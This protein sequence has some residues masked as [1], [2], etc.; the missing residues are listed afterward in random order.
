MVSKLH[1]EIKHVKFGDF[2]QLHIPITHTHTEA[3]S[4]LP[5]HF[6][7]N[8]ECMDGLK[9][10]LQ[11]SIVAFEACEGDSFAKRAN[12]AK[13][14]LEVLSRLNVKQEHDVHDAAPPS[15]EAEEVR[16]SL[17]VE[18]TENSQ[19]QNG[20]VTQV[21]PTG[22]TGKL[23][24]YFNLPKDVDS[25]FCDDDIDLASEILRAKANP[26]YNDFKVWAMNKFDLEESDWM[27]GENDPGDDYK[28]FIE[29]LLESGH[30]KLADDQPHFGDTKDSFISEGLVTMNVTPAYFVCYST[31]DK[32]QK[33]NNPNL[34]FTLL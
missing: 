13:T 11:S 27:F 18:A 28:D 10:S 24:D 32:V 7:K 2:I 25:L 3:M 33:Q 5:L 23:I 34:N 15:G 12:H 30:G 19:D 9:E 31:G 29:W 17:E 16:S 1:F 4:A 22:V 26:H 21:S 8:K 6:V 20:A 14:A